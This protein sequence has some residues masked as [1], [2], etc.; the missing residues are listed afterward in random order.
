M[1]EIYLIAGMAVVT[2]SIRYVLFAIAGRFE[3]PKPIQKALQYVPPTVLT[4]IIV[5]SILYPSGEA[6]Q[7]NFQNAYLFGGTVAFGVGLW[8]K[9]LLITILAGMASFLLWRWIFAS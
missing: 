5:P 8:R 1:F 7:L 6:L 4:A 3:F 2:F 9:N